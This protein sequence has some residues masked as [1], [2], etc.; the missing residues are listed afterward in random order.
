MLQT[1]LGLETLESWLQSALT[2][3]NTPNT[4]TSY[5]IGYANE[6]KTSPYAYVHL[7]GEAWSEQRTRHTEHCQDHN[8]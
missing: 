5:T 1:G 7:L 2:R 4:P 6:S 8:R 3:Y